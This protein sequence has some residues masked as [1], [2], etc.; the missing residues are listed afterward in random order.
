[1]DSP[2]LKKPRHS[3]SR[4]TAPRRMQT[5][6]RVPKPGDPSSRLTLCLS[7][8]A[9]S[10]HRSLSGS[11]ITS[12]QG[13]GIVQKL[14]RAP[15]CLPSHEEDADLNVSLDNALE[16]P[17]SLDAL[18]Q[19]EDALREETLRREAAQE[20]AT[21]GDKESVKIE[22]LEQELQDEEAE[23]GLPRPVQ[24]K[25]A[26]PVAKNRSY[27]SS[28]LSARISSMT[29]NLYAT[30]NVHVHEQMP[31]KTR[32]Y[33]SLPLVDAA[34]QAVS[35]AARA[36]SDTLASVVSPVAASAVATIVMARPA[37]SRVSKKRKSRRRRTLLSFDDREVKPLEEEAGKTP[38]S[39]LTRYLNCPSPCAKRTKVC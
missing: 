37:P 8:P 20:A 24:M 11:I 6:F 26:H 13:H 4:V 31:A 33:S 38:G 16:D 19:R 25:I 32:T 39:P 18:L 3:Q 35:R 1:M 10:R 7:S 22:A 15:V 36:Y 29:T 27:I 2:P 17:I 9:R 30:S 5:T 34:V 28:A 12:A 21:Q 23:N 14:F